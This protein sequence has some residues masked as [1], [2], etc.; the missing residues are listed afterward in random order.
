MI[1]AL[2][3]MVVTGRDNLNWHVSINGVKVGKVLKPTMGELVR[4]RKVKK[5]N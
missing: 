1:T 3:L 2:S 4:I 5:K